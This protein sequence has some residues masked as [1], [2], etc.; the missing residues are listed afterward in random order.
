MVLIITEIYRYRKLTENS[1]IIRVYGSGLD[2]GFF[3]VLGQGFGISF[4][5]FW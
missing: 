2:Y 4:G 1:V 3:R 5:I